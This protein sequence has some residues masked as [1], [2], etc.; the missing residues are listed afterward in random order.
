MGTHANAEE[1]PVQRFETAFEKLRTLFESDKADVVA[2]ELVKHGRGPLF[3]VEGLAR[4]YV[5]G[6][7]E[8]AELRLQS[9]ALEDRVGRL[10]DWGEHIE[11]AK[12]VGVPEKAIAYLERRRQQAREEFIRYLK[13][14]KFVG[15]KKPLIQRWEKMVSKAEWDGPK[16]DRAYVLR[17]L[18]E[19]T[20]ELRKE[21]WDM[22]S[23]QDGLHD[24]RRRVRWLTIYAQALNGLV[25]FDPRSLVKFQDIL[26]DPITKSPYA[27][28]PNGSHPDCPILFPREV[29][30]ALTRAVDLLGRA[31]DMG[32]AMHEWLPEALLQSGAEPTT[33]RARARAEEL[34]RKHPKYVPVIETG[35][36]V[37]A[38]LRMNDHRFSNK[39]DRGFLA[40]AKKRLTDQIDWSRADCREALGA[41]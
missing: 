20:Q 32:E 26:S 23:L 18:I 38:E 31:K 1:G 2:D 41:L 30:L 10:V 17:K 29:F 21:N 36:A 25:V 8:M 13:E 5:E 3:A 4:L 39:E 12:Q 33:E 27:N 24:F 35:K 22:S 19:L 37:M 7:P 16:K 40:A 15:G 9:K 6:F 11:L 14:E 34:V 28:L